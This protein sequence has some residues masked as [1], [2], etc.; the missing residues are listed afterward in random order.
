MI[1]RVPCVVFDVA[2]TA[3]ALTCPETTVDHS[4]RCHGHD[5]AIGRS[6]TAEPRSTA[7]H[8]LT[9][10]EHCSES[11]TLLE[12][13]LSSISRYLDPTTPLG[14]RIS[15][16]G[17]SLAALTAT[18]VFTA[19]KAKRAERD[20]PP[21]GTFIKVDGVRLHYLDRGTGSP[22][23]L[24]HGNV[25]RLQDFLASGLVDR[26]AEHH[27]V[28]AFDRPGYGYSERPRD[29]LWTADAQAALLQ[30]AL[31]QL[32]LD[33]PMEQGQVCFKHC[34]TVHGSDI[35]RSH[36]PRVSLA[37]HMPVTTVKRH[38]RVKRVDVHRDASESGTA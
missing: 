23:V 11:L 5:L 19:L 37:I 7:F 12:N 15:V 28:I 6:E 30:G 13:F 4:I 10:F 22:V 36:L 29:R 25:V 33:E 1:S 8:P 27:R 31:A 32:A 14:R 35:N 3:R 16:G 17:L 18:A 24:L 34:R 26:L 21:K 2:G 9:R 38:P 20:N